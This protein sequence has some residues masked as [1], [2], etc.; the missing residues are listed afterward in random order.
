MDFAAICNDGVGVV[1]ATAVILLLVMCSRWP[2]TDKV[3]FICVFIVS[4]C[5]RHLDKVSVMQSNNNKN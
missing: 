4:F 1:M 5:V 3:Y 2:N